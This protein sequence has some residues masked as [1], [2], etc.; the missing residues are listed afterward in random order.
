MRLAAAVPHAPNYVPL[1]TI[2]HATRT[3]TRGNIRGNIKSSNPSR[4]ST[5]PR[6][7]RSCAIWTDLHFP[8]PG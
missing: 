6:S 1:G 2:R 8:A 7:G 4:S 5:R 3:A